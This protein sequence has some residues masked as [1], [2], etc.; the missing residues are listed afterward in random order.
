M[1]SRSDKTEKPTQRRIQKAKEEGQVAKSQE[2]SVAVSLVLLAIGA[3]ILVTHLS[4]H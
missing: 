2:V 3:R 1:T 4:S